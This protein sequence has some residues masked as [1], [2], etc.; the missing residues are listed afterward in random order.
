MSRKIENVIIIVLN[1]IIIQTYIIIIIS[2]DIILKKE[3]LLVI[4]VN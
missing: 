1:A 2:N 4:S 3:V